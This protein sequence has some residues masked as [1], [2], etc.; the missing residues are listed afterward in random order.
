MTI[1]TNTKFTCLVLERKILMT[2][3][4]YVCT[5]DSVASMLAAFG[6]IMND[7]DVSSRTSRR[8][9]T[10]LN[11]TSIVPFSFLGND[12]AVRIPSF[13]A[14]PALS[15]SIV[16]YGTLLSDSAASISSCDTD[17]LD[18]ASLSSDLAH[19][20]TIHSVIV[21][22][23]GSV[24]ESSISL[25]LA[26]GARNMCLVGDAQQLAPFTR[27][28]FDHQ[29]GDHTHHARSMLERA[30]LAGLPTRFLDTQYRMHPVICTLV[31]AM[32]YRRAL[33]S[34]ATIA[35]PHRAS[36]ASGMCWVDVASGEEKQARGF[37]NDNE[38]VACMA[39]VR[40]LHTEHPNA[41]IFILAMYK[42]Q[43]IA[44]NR[45]LHR[46]FRDPP[47]Q[48]TTLT[49]DSAQGE[50]ADFVILS[51]AKSF[52]NLFLCDRRRLCV[53]LSRAKALCAIVGNYRD[54]NTDQDWSPVT[55]RCEKLPPSY[56]R[57]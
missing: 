9:P 51:L 37:T 26:L 47:S 7:D 1:L 19:L 42:Q 34:H 20:P 17:S 4:A 38:V 12:T 56:S 6:K 40:R 14:I 25:L 8:R 36:F 33:V 24:S 18:N 29:H 5:I 53:A 45:R 35:L 57:M 50:E 43:Q 49:V 46:M 39:L 27:V 21:D 2:A 41:R 28:H 54:Y 23:A 10:R 11:T 32:F 16:G 30:E 44:L 15:T 48:V 3:N 31:S 52:P 22:E 13:Q 55:S